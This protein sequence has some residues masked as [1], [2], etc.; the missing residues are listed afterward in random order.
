MPTTFS[1][2]S[3]SASSHSRSPCLDPLAGLLMGVHLCLSQ[4]IPVKNS[5][6]FLSLFLSK[7][8]KLR[9]SQILQWPMLERGKF[10][11][12]PSWVLVA[13]PMI[14]LTQDRL[15][16]EKETNFNSCTWGLVKIGPKKWSRQAAF[17]LFRQR[18]NKFVRNWQDKETWVWDAQLV[19]NL[20]RTWAWGSTLK[21]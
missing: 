15:T 6:H 20:N 4:L 18:N 7:L 12:Y 10:S 5:F 14:K 21:K 2:S 13:G 8:S 11:L 3:Y 17:I 1:F 16:G 19:K 9:V